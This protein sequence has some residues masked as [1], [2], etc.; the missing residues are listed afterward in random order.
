MGI[1]SKIRAIPTTPPPA[2]CYDTACK[3]WKLV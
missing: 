3:D 2:L 1:L